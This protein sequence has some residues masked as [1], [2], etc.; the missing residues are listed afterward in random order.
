MLSSS[1][2]WGAVIRTCIVWVTNQTSSPPP[3]RTLLCYFWVFFI[4]FFMKSVLELYWSAVCEAHAGFFFHSTFFFLNNLQN[5]FFLQK[6]PE[7]LGIKKIYKLFIKNHQYTT[8]SRDFFVYF[9]VLLFDYYSSCDCYFCLFKFYSI[10][11]VYKSICFVYL[12]FR[13][14]YCIWVI[15]LHVSMC[16]LVMDGHYS[17]TRWIMDICNYGYSYFFFIPKDAQCS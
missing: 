16:Q 17:T 3:H 2:L 12:C 10:K 4:I 15:V 8:L 7:I 5:F 11:F 13:F 6:F 9:I 14:T 1:L